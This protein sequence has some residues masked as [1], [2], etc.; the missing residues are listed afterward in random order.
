MGHLIASSSRR[1][2]V[3]GYWP[4]NR[5]VKNQSVSA[6]SDLSIGVVILRFYFHGISQVFGLRGFSGKVIGKGGE[7]EVQW[8][9]P[10]V[11]APVIIR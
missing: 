4:K 8:V 3:R 6:R 7:L 10:A 9:V 5:E 1:P 2:F 11:G